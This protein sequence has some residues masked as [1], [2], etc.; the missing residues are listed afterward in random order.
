MANHRSYCF[1]LFST[2]FI[3]EQQKKLFGQTHLNFPPEPIVSFWYKSNYL[4]IDAFSFWRIPFFLQKDC[5][6]EW[7]HNYLC[8]QYVMDKLNSSFCTMQHAHAV[9]LEQIS[10]YY[11]SPISKRYK[12]ICKL[13]F[14]FTGIYVVM[15]TQI[16][17]HKVLNM[18]MKRNGFRWLTLQF[19]IRY[20]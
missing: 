14:Q 20:W 5:D 9:L 12:T 2:Q 13:S 4:L 15:A 17:E 8:G 6:N 1:N 16:W 18:E 11:K 10:G 19:K 3:L 7:S